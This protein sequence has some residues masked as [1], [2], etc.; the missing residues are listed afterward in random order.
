MGVNYISLGSNAR[1]GPTGALSTLPSARPRL[2]DLITLEERVSAGDDNIDVLD[3]AFHRRF[4]Q[5][6][7]YRTASLAN[8]RQVLID[9]GVLPITTK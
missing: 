4:I 6:A 5:D 2:G 1:I 9:D 8:S 7:G 3:L